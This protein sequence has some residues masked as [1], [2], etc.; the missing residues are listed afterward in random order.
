LIRRAG[1]AAC[2]TCACLAAA[3][4]AAQPVADRWTW[5]QWIHWLPGWAAAAG[6]AP[7]FL[8]VRRLARHGRARTAALAAL[9]AAAVLGVA[10]SAVQ[11]VGWRLLPPAVDGTL[12]VTHWNARWPGRAA[13]E[14][15][16]ALAPELGDVAVLSSPGSMLRADVACEWVPPGFRCRDLGMFGIVSRWPVVGARMLASSPL[17]ESGTVWIGWFEVELPGGDALSILAIDLPSDPWLPRGELAL[18]LRALLDAAPPPREPDLVVGDLNCTP[19]SVVL[20]S[21]P[22]GTA[23]APPWAATGWLATYPA[24]FPVLRIDTMRIGPRWEWCDY[25]TW[26]LGVSA[27]LAQHARIRAR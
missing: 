8:I 26:R 6:A 12:A 5:S 4:I 18:R 15:G 22:R 25:R 3:W 20:S 2:W 23:A 10:R 14:A 13:L 21:L 24:D 16:R 19:G 11:D 7:A 17:G 1:R 9:G 27:H